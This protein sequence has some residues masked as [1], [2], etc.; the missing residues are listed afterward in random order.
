MS[1]QAPADLVLQNAVVYTADRHR[2]WAEAVAVKAGRIAYVGGSHGA[3][4]LAGP[5]TEVLD[6]HRKLVLPGFRDAHVHALTGSFNLLECRLTGPADK[7][8]YLV[9]VVAYS[10]ANKNQPFIR[11]GG[12]LPGGF[13]PSGP[14][15]RDLDAV[16][17]DRPVMLKAIDGHSAWVNTRALEQAGI[18]RDTP[19][20]PGGRIVRDPVTGNPTGTLR[21]WSAMDLVESRLPRPTHRDLTAAGWAF[22]ELATRFG[23]VSIHEAM[24]GKEELDVYLAFDRNRELIMRVQASL[25]CEPEKGLE[26]I[27]ELQEMRRFYQGHLLQPRSV[28]LF[29]DG[30]VEG[31]T[32]RLLQP[33]A[34]RPA[35]RGELLWHRDELNGII[36][37]LDHAGF[38]I[39]VHAI[40]DGAVR[41]MLDAYEDVLRKG[42]RPDARHMIAHGDLI[43]AADM[44]RFRELGVIANMQPAWFC[45]ERSFAETVLSYLGSERAYSLYKINSLLA[46]G[47]QVVCSSDWPFSGELNTFNPLDAIQVGVTR[48][49]LGENPQKPYM[50]GERVDPAALIDCFTIE[51][52]RADFQENITGS[53]TP[54]KSADLVVLDRNLFAIPV[55]EIHHARVLMTLFEGRP[56]F[57]DS[58]I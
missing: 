24:A 44:P 46:A 18:T 13:P 17:S 53:L 23:V 45:E 47:A 48:A 5:K 3:A 41:M 42:G 6:L 38:Q 9:Q 10:R 50:P 55:T 54:G 8:A 2:P 58:S 1:S 35:F 19:D 21:E 37:A 29:L 22:M 39:H 11:G 16:V 51:S 26:Q 57:R 20:P 33:Y 14:D 49:G 56:V 12:W 36:A 15:R 43:D 40:G 31:H 7:N 52:A 28:K 34:D 30:V 25:L 27:R 32:A 4:A